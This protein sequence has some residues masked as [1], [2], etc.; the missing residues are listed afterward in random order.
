MV[1]RGQRHEPAALPQGKIASTL[2]TGGYVGPRGSVEGRRKYPALLDST[3]DRPVR[4]ECLYRLLY[5]DP[6]NSKFVNSVIS[7]HSIHRSVNLS[8]VKQIACFV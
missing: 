4:S 8:E 3:P 1:M 5:S 7:L 6:R 2:F